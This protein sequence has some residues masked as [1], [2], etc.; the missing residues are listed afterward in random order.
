MSSANFKIAQSIFADILEIPAD[1]ITPTSTPDTLAG[2]DSVRHMNLILALEEEL[3]IEFSESEIEAT[4][5]LPGIL[6][7]LDAKLI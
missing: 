7:L 4:N 5:D 6:K 1:R 3:G 2:W